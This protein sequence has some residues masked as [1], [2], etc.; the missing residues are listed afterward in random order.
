MYF[1]GFS[2]IINFGSGSPKKHFCE[3]FL[4][5]G[6]SPSLATQWWSDGCVGREV[7]PFQDK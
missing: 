6:Y 5:S 1:K 4:K 3:T 2:I 7:C